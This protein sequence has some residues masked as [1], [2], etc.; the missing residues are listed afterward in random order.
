M[1]Y[2]LSHLSFFL[3][4]AALSWLYL[5]FW[6]A[7]CYRQHTVTNISL[8]ACICA[9]HS[10]SQS[11][12]LQNL[13]IYIY[14]FVS[15]YTQSPVIR[16]VSIFQPC[17]H[18]TC[19]SAK[20]RIWI[21]FFLSFFFRWIRRRR[22]QVMVCFNL[23]AF[24]IVLHVYGARSHNKRAWNKLMVN[25]RQPIS[26]YFC[27]KFYY[28]CFFFVL[29]FVVSLC[30]DLVENFDTDTGNVL[31][32]KLIKITKRK[33]ITT[34]RR[35]ENKLKRN[36]F[37]SSSWSDIA[38]KIFWKFTYEILLKFVFHLFNLIFFSFN[39]SLWSFR[40]RHI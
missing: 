37:L 40:F 35:K 33:K 18:D 13:Y 30:A 34:I 10:F 20:R 22:A 31:V 39:S 38:F 27:W 16:F 17:I 24:S 28:F 14:R 32:L 29:V 3:Y 2:F 6:P 15:V 1:L 21:G 36:F 9:L 25:I 4:N 8:H 11:F 7:E 5:Y 19:V 26:S 23:L 12:V